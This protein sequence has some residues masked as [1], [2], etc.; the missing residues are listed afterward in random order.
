MKEK[1]R[2]IWSR[3]VNQ[4]NDE[5]RREF[6]LPQ[7]KIY[8]NGNEGV[9]TH[10]FMCHGHLVLPWSCILQVA[11]RPILMSHLQEVFSIITLEVE[12]KLGMLVLF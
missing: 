9:S 2:V 12:M 8:S 5:K 1:T 7:T 4:H 10:I 11:Q 6:I 3:E